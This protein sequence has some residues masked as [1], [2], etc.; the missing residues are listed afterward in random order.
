MFWSRNRFRRRPAV[1]PSNHPLSAI[2]APSLNPVSCAQAPLNVRRHSEAMATK[3]VPFPHPPQASTTTLPHMPLLSFIGPTPELPKTVH[4]QDSSPLFPLHLQ[5]LGT[6][7][8]EP[9]LDSHRRWLVPANVSPNL[10]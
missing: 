4:K 10:P 6:S 5:F 1:A 2:D 9:T 7:L 8:S 3:R